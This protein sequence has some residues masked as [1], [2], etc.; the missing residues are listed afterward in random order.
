MGVTPTAGRVIVNISAHIWD[1]LRRRVWGQEIMGVSNKK[2]GSTKSWRIIFT[3]I[4]SLWFILLHDYYK[5]SRYN[6]HESLSCCS[7][8]HD[9]LSC[10][11]WFLSSLS[12]NNMSKINSSISNKSPTRIT[13]PLKTKKKTCVRGTRFVPGWPVEHPWHPPCF[14]KYRIERTKRCWTRRVNGENIE[15]YVVENVKYVFG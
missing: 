1:D 5:Y 9:P 15:T 11:I 4:Y 3:I 13:R 6:Y 8:G 14:T 12:V 2:A 7:Q 10:V